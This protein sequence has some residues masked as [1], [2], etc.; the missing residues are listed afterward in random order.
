MLL[1]MRVYSADVLSALN[2]KAA[3]VSNDVNGW[4]YGAYGHLNTGI[5]M[6]LTVGLGGFYLIAPMNDI[7]ATKKSVGLDAYARIDLPVLPVNPY[8]RYGIAI[9]ETV[10]FDDVVAA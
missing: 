8:A 3:A 4:Q 1:W 2:W 7:D 6:V 9:K 10:E 5:P